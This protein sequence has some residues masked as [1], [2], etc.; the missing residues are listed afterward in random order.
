MVLYSAGRGSDQ[1]YGWGQGFGRPVSGQC[2]LPDQQSGH[3]HAEAAGL[4]GHAGQSYGELGQPAVTGEQLLSPTNTRG[5]HR[6]FEGPGAPVVKVQGGCAFFFSLLAGLC[7]SYWRGYGQGRT[8]SGSGEG[9]RK[10]SLSCEIEH[11]WKSFC[12]L[13]LD[14]DGKKC[15]FSLPL[16]LFQ[17]LLVCAL[18]AGLNKNADLENSHM[19]W[20]EELFGLL[21]AVHL[22]D[23][24]S[25]L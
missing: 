20:I 21:R 17:H 13:F 4:S 23:C 1:G 12:E 10:C 19:V 22:T 14:L 24:H 5:V 9:S 6:H 25:S 16:T 7:K 2:Q 18:G 11:F 8:H 15:G 3:H